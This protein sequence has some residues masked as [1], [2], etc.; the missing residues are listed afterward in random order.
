[1]ALDARVQE[2]A[3]KEGKRGKAKIDKGILAY[4]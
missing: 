3:K 2:P 4:I 1:M